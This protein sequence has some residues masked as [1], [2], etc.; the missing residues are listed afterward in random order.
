MPLANQRFYVLNY[1]M[2]LCP[3]G[4]T[5][6]LFIGGTGVAE[7][8]MNDEEKTKAAFVTHPQFGRLYRT[9]DYGAL[10]IDSERQ[11]V[12][13]EFQGR[14]DH[15]IKIRGHRIELGEIETCLL[16][17]DFISNA[18]VADKIDARGKQVLCAY[19]I[20][21]EELTAEELKTFLA[22]H[23]PEYMI[24]S[25]Y[26]EMDEMPL[27]PNGKIDRKKLPKIELAI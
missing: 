2:Q 19:Y 9:G 16:K 10:R 8:Y 13:I 4:V 17:H 27:T 18:V 6:E 22:R 26:I 7:G 3:I 5:G 24:P 15:Q 1:E 11:Q 25:F 12:Y 23:L 20:A 21:D 14:K